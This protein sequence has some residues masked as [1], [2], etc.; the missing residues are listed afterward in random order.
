MKLDFK[1]INDSLFRAL[2]FLSFHKHSLDMKIVARIVCAHSSSHIC[3]STEMKNKKCF[4]YV[5]SVSICFA[6]AKNTR[7][8]RSL[9]YYVVIILWTSKRYNYF[10]RLEFQ[11]FEQ[12]MAL[13][14]HKRHSIPRSFSL[15]IHLEIVSQFISI[16]NAALWLFLTFGQY[17]CVAGNFLS[18]FLKLWNCSKHFE[19]LNYKA[20]A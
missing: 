6:V 11:T 16:R 12:M 18:L 14:W 1:C 13:H 8:L 7:Y 2:S 20:I 15:N 5:K 19:Q 3:V 4:Y 9:H 17:L 10:T